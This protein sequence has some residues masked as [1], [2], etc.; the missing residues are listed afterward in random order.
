MSS[1]SIENVNKSYGSVHILKDINLDIRRGE[2]LTLLVRV[3]RRSPVLQK[4]RIYLREVR[5]RALR[6]ERVLDS[7]RRLCEGLHEIY[8]SGVNLRTN[9]AIKLLALLGA[10]FLPLNFLV[11][12]FGM[13]LASLRDLTW[14][15]AWLLLLM[16]GVAALTV[17][18][19]RRRGWM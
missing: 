13:N 10:V 7:Q 3:A 19:F 8:L 14:S 4:S 1:L 16:A 18:W 11:G 6:L 2:L 15:P 12:F 17:Y 9:Q 5:G